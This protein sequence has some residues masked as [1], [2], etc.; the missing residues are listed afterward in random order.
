[1]HH[2]SRAAVGLLAVL[3]GGSA[4]AAPRPISEAERAAVQIAVDYLNRGPQAVAEQLAATSPLRGLPPASQLEEIEVRLGPPAGAAWELQTAVPS[5]ADRMAIFAVEFPSGIDD[6]AIFDLT[7]EG[8][9]YKVENIR[10]LGEKSAKTPI[11]PPLPPEPAVKADAASGFSSAAIILTLAVL[12]AALAG[13]GAFTSGRLSRIL[14][15]A[16]LAIA[17]G[18]AAMAIV[19]DPRFGVA[20]KKIEEVKAP[21]KRDGN[22]RLAALLPL[23]RAIAAGGAEADALFAKAP[24]NDVNVW[25]AQWELQQTRP[26]NAAKS[27]AAFPSPSD[28]PLAEIVRARLALLNGSDA[29]AVL[30]YERAINLGPGRD[31]LWMETAQALMALGFDDRATEYLKRTEEIGSRA[32]DVYYIQAMLAASKNK[33]QDAEAKLKTAWAM[34]PVERARLVEAAVLW[35]VLRSA[36]MA[37]TVSLAT[38]S[39]ASFAAPE[40]GSRVI[41]FPANAWPS[42]SGSFLHLQIGDQELDVPGGAALA[43]P[44]ALAVDAATWQRDEDVRAMKQVPQLLASAN[45]GAYASPALRRRMVRAAR[46]LAAHNRWDDLVTLTNGVTP[47]AEHMPSELFFLRSKALEH[48]EHATEAKQVMVS[49]AASRVL[50]R[51]NDAQALADL[52]NRLASFDEY[53][54]AMKLLER[55]QN[56]RQRGSLDDRLRQLDM[57]KRL[58]NAFLTYKT[59]HF[60]I[61][62]PQ[63]TGVR[64]AEAMGAILEKELA[65]LQQWVPAPSFKPVIINVLEWR[66]FRST[67]T[68]SDFILGFYEGKI[69]LPFAGIDHFSPP[70]VTILSHELLHAMLAQAT[71]GQAPH[72]FQEGL[73]QRIEMKSYSP[74]AFNMYTDDKLLALT[75]LDAVLRGSP[76]PEMIEQAYI[77][78]QTTIRYV[79]AKYGP[80]G[81]TKL[82]AAFRD[83]ATTEDAIQRLSGGS[84]AKFDADMRAWGRS[85]AHVFDNPPVIDYEPE[86]SGIHFSRRDS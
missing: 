34:R 45:A 37:Q 22:A 5:V 11:F 53:D 3:L 52:G 79:E 64:F 6:A 35:S 31:G 17:V 8:N 75:L 48:T 70:V 65:R 43:P 54:A 60:E 12:A 76:D 40:L 18:A 44:V 1:M 78:S 61:H 49:L 25:R 23:R 14:I 39:E 50:Q 67:Y 51:K 15:P 4:L 71:H 19:N 7:K 28:V 74:N 86:D 66:D 33:Q 63:D 27:L 36:T 83:G 57:N 82:I 21:V 73:A 42:I 80:T 68:G 32:A 38:P 59:P 26:E 69:T 29:N 2:I 16:A 47:A 56:I 85:A 24:R 72:W 9:A 20:Q 77:E 10:M 13:A 84:L 41:G 81:V 55:A 58:A 46:A 30:A 62:Y